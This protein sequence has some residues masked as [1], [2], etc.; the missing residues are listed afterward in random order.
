MRLQIYKDQ[1][2]SY[3][4]NAHNNWQLHLMSRLSI[5]LGMD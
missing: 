4:L 1:A 3:P 5:V 2:L